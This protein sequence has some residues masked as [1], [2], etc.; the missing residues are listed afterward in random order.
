MNTRYG[1][2]IA[3][4]RSMWDS[5]ET[6]CWPIDK[7]AAIVI[8]H[9][10]TWGSTAHTSIPPEIDVEPNEIL[11]LDQVLDVTRAPP[12]QLKDKRGMRST[13]FAIVGFSRRE[14]K[15]AIAP[16]SVNRERVRLGIYKTNTIRLKNSRPTKHKP[17]YTK[18][19]N[20]WFV[21]SREGVIYEASERNAG[22]PKRFQYF[23]LDR[24][25]EIK[26]R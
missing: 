24:I 12:P 8:A 19:F 20:Y 22:F 13:N 14:T 26:R 17:R 7:L 9:S 11:S 25:N 1:A 2:E 6:H 3:R 5:I 4:M 10:P 23:E 21:M 15:R 16:P 18:G